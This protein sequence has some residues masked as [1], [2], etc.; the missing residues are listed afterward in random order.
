M[1]LRRSKEIALVAKQVCRDLRKRSTPPEQAFWDQ[2]RDRRFQGPKFYRQH[3]LF[4]DLDGGETFFVADFYCHERKLVVEIDG[5]IHDYHKQHDAARTEGINGLG[6]S[7]VRF[8]NE[9]IE[10]NMDGVLERLRRILE[11]ELTP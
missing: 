4:V 8:R 7:V 2:V 10:S 5:K 6:V 11:N 1:S 9:E 3:P